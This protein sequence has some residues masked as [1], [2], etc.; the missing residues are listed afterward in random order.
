M[1]LSWGIPSKRGCH[2]SA[3]FDAQCS[4][5]KPKTVP[6]A[7]RDHPNL[8]LLWCPDSQIPFNQVP[9]L[10]VPLLQVPFLQVPFSQTPEFQAPLYRVPFNQ[11]P[12][13]QTPPHQVPFNQVPR[14]QVPVTQVPVSQPPEF[15]TPSLQVTYP[16]ESIPTSHHSI[17]ASFSHSG[18]FSGY[19]SPL[20]HL[21]MPRE[22]TPK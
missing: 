13:C 10:Q 1:T 12:L 20:V 15:Q 18:Q 16:F 7:P 14:C 17:S 3:V 21:V 2:S 5:S 11:I 22:S 19:G 4:P 8:G 6:F 9:L